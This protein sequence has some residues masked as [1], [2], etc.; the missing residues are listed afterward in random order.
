MINHLIKRLNDNKGNYPALRIP[1][2][3][4]PVEISNLA[5][6]LCHH[7]H[8][9]QRVAAARRALAW[10]LQSRPLPSTIV[11]VEAAE[12]GADR[13]FAA[14]PGVHYIART[15]GERSRGIWLKEALWTIA[16]NAAL[17][18]SRIEGLV[19]LDVDCA[20]ARQD[21]ATAVASAL[22]EH[23]VISPHSH[24]YYAEQD[25][26]RQLGF[27]ESAGYAILT[28]G[29]GGHPGMALGMTRKFFVD[30]LDS[31]IPLLSTGSGDTLFWLYVAGKEKF[32]VNRAAFSHSLTPRQLQGTLPA[33]RIG[34][35][36]Q[37]IVH[38]PHGPLSD[39]GYRERMVCTRASSSAL[40]DDFEYLEDGMPAWKDTPGGRLLSKSYPRI[41]EIA[42]GGGRIST[43][44]SRDIYDEEAV[45]EYGA[46]DDEHP[47]IITTL[48]RSGGAYGP[49]HVHW[50]K[51][52]LDK[53]CKVPF[54]FVCQSDVDVP[55]IETIP[56]VLDRVDGATF[57][58]QVEHY[59]DIW[60][61]DASVLTCDLDTVVFR[62]FT[63]HRCPEG[64]LFMLR[65][66]GNWVHSIWA[67]WGGGLTYFRG[68][69]SFIFQSFQL[70]CAAGGQQHP[71]FQ[72]I[73]VQEF[74]TSCLRARGMSPRDIEAH[75]C[76]RY[77]QGYR[78]SISPEAHFAI[79]PDH[80]KPWELTPRPYW[81]PPLEEKS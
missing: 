1:A 57:W 40:G 76:V 65:E 68:D 47:L 69:F 26:G 58:G 78:E 77:Y 10:T 38:Y 34:H 2:A 18:D 79:F 48:L 81:V 39:R 44:M 7:G 52:Q 41:L 63:P 70:D 53:H 17:E 42:R 12:A 32:P 55:G 56:L 72:C 59:R 71:H 36:N 19:F 23:D 30:T 43:V 4:A 45:K 33:P 16:A 9:P 50:L 64:E 22:R 8:N 49:Q 35:A 28:K 51:R 24:M 67:T 3:T 29:K 13:Y 27:L 73:A 5:L 80:P 60:P 14:L 11:M 21:W 15:I 37:L 31:R 20:F 66:I 25:D 75:F 46:I 54:R 6:V 61:S 74:V 62:D